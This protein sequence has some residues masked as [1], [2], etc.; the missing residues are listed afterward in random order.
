M[1]RSDGIGPEGRRVSVIGL[2]YVGLPVA[3][4]AARAIDREAAAHRIIAFD[5]DGERVA[6]LRA[7]R[8]R[9]G[10]AGAGELADKRLH[11]TA[12]ADDLTFADFHIVTV[13]TPVDERHEPDLTDLL[14]A[15]DLLGPRLA[16]GSAVAVESTLYPG[17][18]DNILGPRLAAAS[19]L[20]CGE[21]FKLIYSPE[22]IN[23]G[24]G[25]HAFGHTP[26]II[27]GQDAVA[28]ELA[29]E[30]Y[31][32]LVPAGLVEVSSIAAAEAAKAIEN[33]QRDLNIALVNEFAQILDALDLDT[34]EVLAAAGTKW[35]FHGYRPGLVG[36]HCI[37][38]DPWYLAARA[39]QVGVEPRVLLA[40]RA[41]NDGMPA[42]VARRVAELLAGLAAGGEHRTNESGAR[43][44]VGGGQVDAGGAGG[45]D[46][47]RNP[48]VAA[49]VPAD[50]PRVLILGLTYKDGVADVRH[51]LVPALAVELL[52]L[53]LDVSAWDP[54]VD[55]KGREA[56]SGGGWRVLSEA[57]QMLDRSAGRDQPQQTPF[58]P[59]AEAWEA[60]ILARRH[61]GLV[62]LAAE[63]CGPCSGVPLLADLTGAFGP[64]RERAWPVGALTW[65]L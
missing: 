54:E 24:D 22:R 10:V 14:A 1:N 34:G 43:A 65:A 31:G 48:A 12:D 61:G 37:G 58:M 57:P 50:K 23:P 29:R 40:G 28:L 33:T 2:G 15:M 35:N 53:G 5:R 6:E 27:A 11:F 30:V 42:F 38:V 21:D 46:S 32:P 41:V 18:T 52:G 45:A 62:E 19:K 51:S 25:D 3:L 4:A 26:K 49:R 60:V 7:G 44:A 8:D 64:G 47:Q 9:T 39:R 56:L 55:G 17:A 63:L 20:V 59:G 16:P 13:P 36:G